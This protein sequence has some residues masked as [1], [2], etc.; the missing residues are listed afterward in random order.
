MLQR[1][2]NG[3][4]QTRRHSRPFNE[5]SRERTSDRS[6]NGGWC[7]RPK[8]NPQS[9]HIDSAVEEKV[10]ATS[11]KSLELAPYVKSPTKDRKKLTYRTISIRRCEL[12]DLFIC[13]FLLRLI[14]VTTSMMPMM[15]YTRRNR[16]PG[17]GIRHHLCVDMP[18]RRTAIQAGD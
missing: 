3:A 2:P 6:S 10:R 13:D 8:T 16:L 18:V 4:T 11:L 9:W 14:S 12:R 1:A 7:A 17:F 15:T 5:K